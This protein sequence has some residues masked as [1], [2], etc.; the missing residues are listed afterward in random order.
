[1]PKVTY[2]RAA[3]E[4]GPG[5]YEVTGPAKLTALNPGKSIATDLAQSLDL[6]PHKDKGIS[7][8][9]A[10]FTDGHVKW[11][12]ARANPQAFNPILWQN[13]GAD[14][15]MFRRLANTWQP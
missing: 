14:E 15:L 1:M 6:A 13:L 9:N 10:L 3:I 4:V 2:D 8:L 11:Q 12:S 5:T 7:G